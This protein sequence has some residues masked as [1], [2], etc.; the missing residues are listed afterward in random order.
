MKYLLSGLITILLSVIGFY[1]ILTLL[2]FTVG[3]SD[4][5]VLYALAIVFGSFLIIIINL[6]TRINDKLQKTKSD[7]T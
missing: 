4:E 1:A 5:V 6:L 3:D 2:I 7:F